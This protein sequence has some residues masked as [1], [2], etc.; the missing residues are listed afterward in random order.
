MCVCVL[1]CLGELLVL[2]A[3]HF[4]LAK[5]FVLRYFSFQKSKTLI[6]K[7]TVDRSLGFNIQILDSDVIS[8]FFGKFF[9]LWINH[10]SVFFWIFK[11]NNPI[12]RIL[13]H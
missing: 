1:S 12:R 2:G 3:V 5:L 13:G 8:C 10:F 9:I 11:I 7:S 4:G 6:L